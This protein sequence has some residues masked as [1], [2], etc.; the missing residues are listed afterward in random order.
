[1]PHITIRLSQIRTFLQLMLIFGD[2]VPIVRIKDHH[3]HIS[4]INI[5][6]FGFMKTVSYFLFSWTLSWYPHVSGSG[7][8]TSFP[9]TYFTG[10][11]VLYGSYLHCHLLHWDVNQVACSWVQKVLYKCL[12]LAGFCYCHGKYGCMGFG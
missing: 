2:L 6:I 9:A 4:H 8:C 3:Y 7:R 10:C 1:M 5:V 12:V 11:L